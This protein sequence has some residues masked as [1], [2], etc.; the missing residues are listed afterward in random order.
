MQ[1]YR[2]FAIGEVLWDMLPTGKKVGGAPGNFAYHCRKLGA[3]ADM[4]SRVGDD[5]L[6]REL[7]EFYRSVGL[8]TEFIVVDPEHPT[9][10]VDVELDADGQARYVFR[11]DVAWDHLQADADTL[12]LLRTAD[13]ICY[14]TLA[15]RRTESLRAMLAMIAAPP[16]TTLRVFD[17][18]FRPPHYTKETVL[19]LLPTA[20]ILKLN[21]E[22]LPILGEMFGLTTSDQISLARRLIDRFGFKMLIL[23]RGECGSL[24]LTSEDTS[25]YRSRPVQVVDTVGAG[26]A[27]TAAAVIGFLAGRP[28]DTINRTA[29][30]LAARVCTQPGAMTPYP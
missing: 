29:S 25:D 26:D 27:F 20:D 11:D 19:T 22:E 4:I 10:A 17:V 3:D 8:S 15:G 1:P 18:N 16:K 12:A 2:I 28:L 13:A 24:L 21:D 7:L 5:V 9:G 23:T 14:G 30:D 6:G